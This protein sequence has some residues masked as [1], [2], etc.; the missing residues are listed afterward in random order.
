MRWGEPSRPNR[1]IVGVDR[2]GARILF[3]SRNGTRFPTALFPHRRGDPTGTTW[4]VEDTRGHF[5]HCGW[6]RLTR[7][8]PQQLQERFNRPTHEMV[9]KHLA[10]LTS[11]PNSARQAARGYP[12]SDRSYMA[13]IYGWSG[14][15]VVSVTGL[16][17]RPTCLRFRP[18]TPKAASPI[19]SRHSLRRSS[20]AWT[21]SG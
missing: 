4:L 14:L 11:M 10:R 17:T 5:I 12:R 20:N 21:T 9:D 7:F 3:E 1:S 6:H 19:S 8:L 13:T 18:I 16:S 15:Y 2:N